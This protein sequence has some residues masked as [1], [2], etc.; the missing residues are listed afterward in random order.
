[1]MAYDIGEAPGKGEYEC[2]N[3]NDWSVTLDD[4]TDVLPP[5]PNCEDHSVQYE[6]V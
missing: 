1:M 3:C 4:A 2:I 5:C 6:R